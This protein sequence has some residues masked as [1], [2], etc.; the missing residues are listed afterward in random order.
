MA[1]VRYTKMS[2]AGNTFIVVDGGSLPPAIDLSHLAQSICAETLDHGG[3]DGFIA[4]APW[5]GGDFEMKYFNR[6]GS[7]GMMCGNG[8]RCA[9]RFAVDAGHVADPSAI[10]FV[11]AGVVYGA[12]LTDRGVRLHFPEPRAFRLGLSVDLFDVERV[13]H[14]GDVGTPHAVIFVDDMNEA[15]IGVVADIPIDRWGAALRNHALF[16][17]GGANANFVEIAPEGEGIR[18]RTFERGVEGETGACGTGA[19]SAG[20]IASLARGV[21]PPVAVV[22]SSGDTLTVDFS[23]EEGSVKNVTLEGN[24]ENLLHGWFDPEELTRDVGSIA[25]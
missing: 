5:D 6:D 20:I 12:E 16:A 17:P 22:T 8:G 11:A 14:F 3:A 19:I 9:V 15:G 10:R 1:S 21:A 18:L 7:S 25:G 23:I 2:G 13:C 24:A 4:V